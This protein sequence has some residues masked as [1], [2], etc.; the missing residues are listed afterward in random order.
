MNLTSRALLDA[1][2][3]GLQ[4]LY[5]ADGRVFASSD[6]QSILH[7][8]KD[9]RSFKSF[10]SPTVMATDVVLAQ[11]T[12]KWMT[13]ISI[14]IGGIPKPDSEFDG[15]GKKVVAGTPLFTG[16]LSASRAIQRTV[17][18]Q[19]RALMSLEQ[20]TLGTRT[21]R[22]NYIL[23]ETGEQ[24]QVYHDPIFQTNCL[25]LSLASGLDSLEGLTNI[26]FL[27]VSFIFMAHRIGED[28]L[29]WMD[30]Q[31]H[32]F[33]EL[34][35]LDEGEIDAVWLRLMDSSDDSVQCDT[36]GPVTHC[37]YSAMSTLLTN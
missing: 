33:K 37:S 16:S 35:G 11:W 7:L 31:Y 21:D 14:H 30:R 28:K 5:L 29:R 20:L 22:R 15:L 26:Q 1:T 34:V 17:Y 10:I 13:V 2:K 19:L 27:V 24:G 23:D 8:G 12:C 4:G 3:R 6:I 18:A 9:L 32:S 36:S 25:E